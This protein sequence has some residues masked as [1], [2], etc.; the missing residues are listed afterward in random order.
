MDLSTELGRHRIVR[1]L[2][3]LSERENMTGLQKNELARRLAEILGIDYSAFA[4]KRMLQLMNAQEVAEVARDGVTYNCTVIATVRP[5]TKSCSGA[6]S[7][8]NRDRI[9]ALTGRQA[10]HFCYPERRVPAGVSGMAGKGERHI[11]HD[12]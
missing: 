4:A 6:K 7:R 9:R 5:R 3:E 1:G 11:G 2:I 8:E 12:L 10:S